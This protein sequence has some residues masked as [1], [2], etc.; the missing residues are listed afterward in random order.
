MSLSCTQQTSYFTHHH[1][2]SCSLTVFFPL[3][4]SYFRTAIKLVNQKQMQMQTLKQTSVLKFTTF[5][6]FSLLAMAALFSCSKDNVDGPPA[7]NADLTPAISSHASDRTSTVAIRY[8]NTVYVPCA[9]GG[10]GEYVQ[11]NGFTNYAY[12]ISW[13]D[14]GATFGY[15]ANSYAIKGVGLTSGQQFIASGMGEGQ[16]YLSWVDGHWL[17][18]FH[19]RLNVTSSSTRFAIKNTYHVLFTPDGDVLINLREHE[20]ECN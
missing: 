16:T 17:S 12:N 3:S 7:K 2:D 6:F 18:V 8:D 15:H 13:T 4:R 11:L 9:N 19:D 1:P 20:V 5:I 10:E 14:N